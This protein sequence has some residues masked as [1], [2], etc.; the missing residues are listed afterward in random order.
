MA[1][2]SNLQPT[3]INGELNAVQQE[4]GDH[5]KKSKAVISETLAESDYNRQRQEPK[6]ADAH[7]LPL[8]DLRLFLDHFTNE[9][10]DQLL[11]YGCGGSPYRSL[12]KANRFLRADY[13]DCGDV[14]CLIAEDGTLPL[15]EA[16]CDG[17]LSTQVL[18]HVFS[19]QAYLAEA[20][21]VLRPGGKLMLSTHGIWEDHGCPYDFWRW[22]TDGLTREVERAGFSVTNA[23]KITTGGRAIAF[24]FSQILP[25]LRASRMSLL[26]LSLTLLRRSA[27]AVPEKRHIWLDQLFSGNRLVPAGTEG[28]GV[29]LCLGIEA[30]KTI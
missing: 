9:T 21:R 17:V 15:P 3:A 2:V 19:P 5:S 30:V 26:G 10:F 7:Y 14:D 6:P 18:E 11:D 24:L 20:F 4:A 12:F 8:A 13:V 16:C 22:T 28:H 27:F 1:P 25:Q 23:Y 29:Y